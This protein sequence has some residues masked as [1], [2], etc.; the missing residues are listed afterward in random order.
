MKEIRDM[1][2]GETESV[3]NSENVNG[4]GY[5]SGNGSKYGNGYGSGNGKR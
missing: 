3:D 2:S 5:G 1:I 4:S